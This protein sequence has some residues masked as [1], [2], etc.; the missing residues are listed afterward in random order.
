MSTRTIVDW[1][2]Q[3]FHLVGAGVGGGGMVLF[4]FIFTPVV[5]DFLPP[6]TRAVLQEEVQSR[7]GFIVFIA[8]ALLTVTGVYNLLFNTPLKG[9]SLK[10]VGDFLGTGYGKAMA[11]HVFVALAVSHL[12]LITMILHFI[13]D[14]D[15]IGATV[16]AFFLFSF[17]IG[18]GALARR[19]GF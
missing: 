11:V 8:A 17:A 13:I 2:M 19:M 15:I 6:E 10:A 7:I 14:I 3:W 12:M 4:S 9:F 1:F 16:A 5:R 18:F